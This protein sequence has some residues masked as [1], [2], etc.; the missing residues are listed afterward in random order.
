MKFSALNVDFSSLTFNPLGSRR[1]MQAGIKEGYSLK[2]CYFT[3]IGSS[4]VK[5]VADRH[6]Y[7]AVITSTN[8]ELFNGVN[9]DDLE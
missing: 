8:D 3:S 4:S 2:N 5:T 9:T 1:P 6:R 7:A